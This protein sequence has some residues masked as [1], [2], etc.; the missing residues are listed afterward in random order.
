MQTPQAELE[1][2]KADL[3]IYF[4]NKDRLKDTTSYKHLR[5]EMV[6]AENRLRDAVGLTMIASKT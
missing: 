4:R 3:F 5:D 6:R 1:T 2:L